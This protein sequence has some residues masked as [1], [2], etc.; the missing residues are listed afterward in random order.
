MG[1]FIYLTV[2]CSTLI[3]YIFHGSLNL[4]C[5]HTLFT[6][7][8]S[9]TIRLSSTRSISSS[10]S[11]Y[12]CSTVYIR[13]ISLSLGILI[14]CS[15]RLITDWSTFS[16]N[17]HI[18]RTSLLCS[19]FSFCLSHYLLYLVSDNSFQKQPPSFSTP[20][21]NLMYATHSMPQFN[22]KSHSAP[23]FHYKIII[24]ASIT[25][26]PFSHTCFKV[27][28]TFLRLSSLCLNF[29]NSLSSE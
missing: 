25:T 19:H 15:Y 27:P 1:T 9:P 12:F 26:F 17:Q 5:G 2:Y 8:L 13:F 21:L 10:S 18:E 11:I 3:F 14:I 20:F 22:H 6:K 7:D 28:A 29:A 4:L 23:P 16:L 24:S